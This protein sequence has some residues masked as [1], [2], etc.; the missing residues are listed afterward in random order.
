MRPTFLGVVGAWL[1]LANSTHAAE[2][3]RESSPG[4][5]EGYSPALYDGHS[6]SSQYVSVRDGT[7]L[8]IDIFRP[9]RSGAVA[10][11]KLPVLWMH[12]PYNRRNY[13]N[14]LTAANYPGKAL[15]LVK[16]GYV[17]AVADFR[18]LYASFGHNAGFNRGEW[19]DWSRFDAY[20]ITEW[21]AKQPWSSG[22]IG[23]WG[24]SATGGSQMQAMTTAPPSLKAIFPMSCEWDV[25]GFVAPGGMTPPQGV[26]TQVMRGGSRAARDKTAVPVD[27]ADGAKLL[28][29]AIAEH[30]KNL[31]TPGYTPFRDSVSADFK[32]QWWLK[33]SPH[34]YESTITASKIAVYTAANWDEGA[35]GYGVAFVFGNL[36][37]PKKM[38]LGPATHCDW[39]TVQKDTGFNLLVEELR[40]FDHWLKGIDNGVMRE[41]AVTYYTYNAAP[42]RQ[43]QSSKTWPL[44]SEKRTNFYLNESA[45]SPQRTSNSSARA[46]TVDYAVTNDN[47]WEKGMSFVTEPLPRDL[48]V[49]G[50]SV[51][52]LWV[53]SSSKDA[54][55]IARL[56]DVAPDGSHRYYSVEGRLRASLRKTEQAPYN[57]L[58]LP[59]HP[60]TQASVQP[61]KP[62]EPVE[63]SFD[64][65]ATSYVF[66]A[67]HR[68]RLTL[69][70]ADQRTSA[71]VSPAPSVKV[72]FGDKTPSALNLP[73]IE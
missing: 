31:E 60:F 39:T 20:D 66:K 38:I 64:L 14:G 73:V 23:M 22:K 8:A 13:R 29:E 70:F 65:Y 43:W 41:P 44:A 15:E 21:L 12:T 71:R 4:R 61:L 5:Y 7:R 18:G 2:P 6:M 45:L 37:N 48:Q 34:T 16:Y 47:F 52:T 50:H 62:G 55:V 3:A 54:D 51:V 32:N 68:I 26:P 24:C 69:N 57:N 67:G 10:T 42:G 53:S 56:D 19:Q 58:G 33:S 46:A 11:D 35:T 49:T 59:W 17:V 30:D 25:Y 63:M 28:G 72:H 1:A 9:T 27:G 40:F 36:K